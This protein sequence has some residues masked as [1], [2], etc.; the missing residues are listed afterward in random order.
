[1]YIIES[2][3]YMRNI[4]IN[5][6]N[7]FNSNANYEINLFNKV[8]SDYLN[9]TEDFSR[10][11]PENLSMFSISTGYNCNNKKFPKTGKFA[12]RKNAT[13][14]LLGSATVKL[15]NVKDNIFNISGLDAVKI[16]NV[17]DIKPVIS[18]LFKE[19]QVKQ[20][21]RKLILKNYWLKK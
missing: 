13:P 19:S 1:M 17:I 2:T 21:N 7:D 15:I 8:S 4:A 14:N 3:R 10:L 9:E 6:K 12:E 20:T 16:I 18:E 5:T 11:I